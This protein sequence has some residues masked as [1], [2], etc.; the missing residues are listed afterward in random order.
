M[1]PS[2]E[3]Q[4]AL[5]AV[6]QAQIEVLIVGRRDD[7]QSSGSDQSSDLGECAVQPL[8]QDVLEHFDDEDD[9]ERTAALGTDDAREPGPV[10]EPPRDL[11]TP[12]AGL[13]ERGD[14]APDF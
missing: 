11:V 1:L 2:V 13:L 12:L 5:G 4:I 8:V 6:T 10:S 3:E 9:V 14:R 7:D